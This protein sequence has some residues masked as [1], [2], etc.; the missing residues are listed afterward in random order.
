MFG[1][2]SVKCD[3]IPQH[4]AMAMGKMPSGADSCCK[5]PGAGMKA[6]AIGTTGSASR[7]EA[8]A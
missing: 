6:K 3:D 4:K 5:Y 8:K 2:G 1:K 7:R